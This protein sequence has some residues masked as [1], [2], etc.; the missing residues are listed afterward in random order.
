MPPS[1]SVVAW[2]RVAAIDQ[3]RRRVDGVEHSFD[4]RIRPACHVTRA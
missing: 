4:A 3:E 2:S 1:A